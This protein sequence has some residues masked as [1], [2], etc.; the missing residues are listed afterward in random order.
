MMECHTSRIVLHIS[1]RNRD[2]LSTEGPH[3]I[4]K[5]VYSVKVY[6]VA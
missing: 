3:K 5:K 4:R 6:N 2:L 1:A